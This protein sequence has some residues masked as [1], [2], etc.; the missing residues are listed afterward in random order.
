MSRPTSPRRKGPE[1]GS[2]D[3]RWNL[4]SL[5]MV[6]RSCRHP[7]AGRGDR[8]GRGAR[9]LRGARR[10]WG[11]RSRRRNPPPRWE[12]LV[13]SEGEYQARQGKETRMA[14]IH[15]TIKRMGLQGFSP[16]GKGTKR[17]VQNTLWNP[18]P[19]SP[20]R[21]LAVVRPVTWVGSFDE[22]STTDP[23]CQVEGT[24]INDPPWEE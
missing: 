17:G 23:F 3:P 11:D 14:R 21:R 1:L 15:G 20:V 7:A 19:R 6:D 24:D 18:P 9:T 2:N 4:V 13:A 10:E 16:K 8:T 22:V 12:C 5:T